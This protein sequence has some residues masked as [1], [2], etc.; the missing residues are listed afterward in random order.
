MARAADICFCPEGYRIIK[1][2]DEVVREKEGSCMSFSI[3][4]GFLTVRLASKLYR[5]WSEERFHGFGIEDRSLD[6]QFLTSCVLMPLFLHLLDLIVTSGSFLISITF[7]FR[8]LFW[9]RFHR[10]D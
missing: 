3:F 6:Y 10:V 7:L 2:G 5:R 9:F 8:T 1:H 4:H